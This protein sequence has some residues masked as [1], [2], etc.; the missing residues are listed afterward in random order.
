MPMEL[1]FDT[2]D[3][4]FDLRVDAQRPDAT[5][6]EV[7]A[8]LR[9]DRHGA[10]PAVDVD[11]RLLDPQTP[12]N[13][14]GLLR[15][16]VLSLRPRGLSDMP[17]PAGIVLVEGHWVAGPWSGPTFLLPPGV[18]VIGR[19]A[20]C[21]VVVDDPAVS[22]EH[23]IVEVS[24]EGGVAISPLQPTNPVEVD[25]TPIATRTELAPDQLVK[26]GS[27]LLTLGPPAPDDRP[28]GALGARSGAPT[29]TFNRPPRHMHTYDPETL[30]APEEARNTGRGVP[31]QVVTLIGGAGGGMAMYFMTRS[32]FALI[33]PVVIVITGLMGQM[34]MKRRARKERKLSGRQLTAA[35]KQFAVDVTAQQVSDRD[36]LR[37]T[38]PYVPEVLRRARV[39]SIRLWER[40]P[41]HNDFLRAMVGTGSIP[42]QPKL[43]SST[44]KSHPD[45]IRTLR[46]H[47]VLDRAPVTVSLAER[48]IVGIAGERRAALGVA[49]SLL[50][51]VATH[52]GPADVTVVLGC[53][54]E[55]LPDWDWAKWLPQLVDP[56]GSEEPLVGVGT[57]GFE[58]V[59]GEIGRSE[60]QAERVTLV[61]V[62]GEGFTSAR[63][64][65]LR[66]LIADEKR[67]FAGIFLADSVD[68]LPA[69][70][71]EVVEVIG[72]GPLARLRRPRQAQ[73]LDGIRLAGVSEHDA[74]ECARHLARYDDPDLVAEGA[75]LPSQA[76][77]LGILGEEYADADTYVQLWG[78]EGADP[79]VRAPVA[80]SEEGLFDVDMAVDGPH[81]LIGGT[82]GSGKSELLRSIVA[83]FAAKCSPLG[84]NFVLIDYKGGSAFDVASGLP[85]TVGMVTDLDEHLGER[86]LR[87]LE[88]E[89]HH[90]ERVL[91][92]AGASDLPAYRKL[93]G[94]PPM[95]RLVV[96]I[97][98]FATMAA[99]I[100]DFLDSLVGVAQRGR[101]L[102]VHL[103]L[104]TQRP[105]GA[106]NANIKANTNLRIAL[107]V[108]DAGDSTDVIDSPVAA[109]L[110]RTR[111]GRVIFRLGPG[112]LVTAQAARVTGPLSASGPGIGLAPFQLVSAPPAPA[113]SATG[114][115]H[116]GNEPESELEAIVAATR[117]AARLMRLP[118]PRRPWPEPLEPVIDLLSLL[119]TP[120]KDADT[121]WL[122]MGDDPDRQAQYPLGWSLA[123]AHL[124]VFGVRNSGTTTA[125]ASAVLSFAHRWGPDRLHAYV[126]DYG[127]GELA[128][129]EGL[130]QV[131]AVI[132]ATE[133]ER[134][135]RLLRRLSAIIDERRTEGVTADA[136]PYRVLVAV[137][138]IG[139]FR[140]GLEETGDP[141]AQGYFDRV[142][143]GAAEV[144]VHFVVS[145]DRVYG[146]PRA[147]IDRCGQKI[148]LQLADKG[149][150]TNFGFRAKD[151]PTFRPGLGLD[152]ASG[153]EIQ[154][155]FPGPLEDAVEKVGARF[156]GMQG[157]PPIGTLPAEVSLR[158]LPVPVGVGTNHPWRVPFGLA[159]A[160]LEAASFELHDAD[161]L[162]VAGPPRSGRS[163]TLATIATQLR[164]VPTSPY[165]VV[166]AV[167]RSPLREGPWRELFDEIVTAA[168]QI[169]PTVKR[170]VDHP[171]PVVLMVD[172]AEA[173]ED[174][175]NAFKDLFAA[176]RSDLHVVAAGRNDA[177]RSGYSHWTRQVRESRRGI[178]VVPALDYDGDL[179]GTNL[180]RRPRLPLL[181]GRGYQGWDGF[182]ELIQVAMP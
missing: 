31:F 86:A 40:R 112:E 103:I 135:M 104:A 92:D 32:P 2:G 78:N 41:G 75:G 23:C 113:P 102:G 17:P 178:L 98:E 25:G 174:K 145:A 8:A 52:H 95:P 111:P 140:A 45:A 30:Q 80:V 33:F 129:L 120:P 18:H 48:G 172:D 19:A 94:V 106:V 76:S 11:G 14:A 147:L 99:D 81:A 97:D 55:A 63:A 156:A 65:R 168:D 154:L 93:P 164:R 24:D 42:W 61:V 114:G 132:K 90:R 27:G 100:P 71:T 160:T 119:D 51:Q 177:L 176:H 133:T 146:V 148:C 84:V 57:E 108:Q 153:L 66:A 82:T 62:D 77:L 7:A 116:A 60:A 12:L 152:T 170:L 69:Q 115:E 21:R 123:N 39:G 79:P 87:C 139:G 171:E 37:A 16:S 167:R 68:Q 158:D 163:T 5:V 181:A 118:E 58:T 88:A 13:H 122:G 134:Q 126:I 155:G 53:R 107:R 141:N 166:V 10:L 96:V 72:D 47:P 59:L 179:V 182:T 121:F 165:L 46:E 109:R 137:D 49:R 143:A 50:G 74:R 89:L 151:L 173:I 149:D 180:P 35:L 15:G 161:H 144:G 36:N 26:I 3:A 54:P 56:T 131:G 169:G 162:L 127:A 43:T 9:R 83:S 150:F 4:T 136:A 142:F 29:V 6:G 70:C 101:S 1:V 38:N 175:D 28:A 125:L 91:R 22:S 44:Y 128:P 138:D 67:P 117:E 34:A 159:D 124:A 105:A 85:H 20:T 157:A 64:T 130:P 110:P 73:L